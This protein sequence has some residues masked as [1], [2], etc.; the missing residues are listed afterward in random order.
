VPNFDGGHYFLTVLLPIKC[1]D[2][3]EHEGIKSSAVHM[4]R[5][6]LSALPVA[7]QSP[8]TERSGL[9]SPFARSTRT[10]FARLVVIDDVAYNGRDPVDA[11]RAAIVGPDPMVA[12]PRDSLNCPFLL[13]VADF[14]ATTAAP[15]QLQSYLRELWSTMEQELRAIMTY[16]VGFDAVHDGDSFA[17]YVQRGQIETTMPFND[18][19]TSAPP[20]TSYQK[21][22][23][24][25]GLV[26][27]G[28]AVWLGLEMGFAYFI[29]A[30]GVV[31]FGLYRFIM[32]RAQRPLPTAPDC[33]LPAILKAIYLQQK[34]TTFAIDA[35]GVDEQTLHRAFG[36]FLESSKPSDRTHPTQPA[37]VLRS[38]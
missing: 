7:Q 25:V 27:A 10:H 24:V 31:L 11:L 15:E 6:A 38:S 30:I 8:V 23:T 19:W 14:D 5:R 22:L 28:L 29:A 13:F 35:Q 21:P 33:E 37:G 26:A 1:G 34:F 9:N 4:V 18:Y 20:L 2:L 16:C 12:Q 36:V 32:T 17:A 3:F